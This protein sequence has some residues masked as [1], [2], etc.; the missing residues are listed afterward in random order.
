MDTKFWICEQKKAP[1]TKHRESDM[2]MD[3]VIHYYND[4]NPEL[5]Y[6]PGSLFL[7]N[8]GFTASRKGVL[9][10]R[11]RVIQIQETLNPEQ[12][13]P[14][15]YPFGRH[16]AS[17]SKMRNSWA[18]T[19]ENIIYWQSST[20][21]QGR[22]VPTLHAWDRD[23][24]LT[25]I[26]WLQ[27]NGDAEYVALGSLVNVNANGVA[28]FFGD[29]QP[30]RESIRMILTAIKILQELTDFKVHLMGFGSSPLTLFLAYYLGASST[31]SAGPRRKA[32]YG[33]IV[34]PRAGERY[35]GNRQASFGM[36]TEL[37]ARKGDFEKLDK[38]TC[39]ICI[40]NRDQLWIDWRARALHNEHVMKAEALFAHRLRESG[41]EAYE[42]FMTSLFAKSGLKH[43]WDE[44]RVMNNYHPISTFLE[45]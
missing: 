40:V 11:D 38:C 45:K 23:S 15:D 7:D 34:L 14:L 1:V 4:L 8:G 19:R 31:D 24:L 32:A 6:E 10:N 27:K 44:A 2:V 22:L 28:G 18:K 9:L 26:K 3:S 42:T 35:V 30:R 36:G 39:Q 25:N 16:N 43:L 21:L 13:I 12:T 20:S 17:Q 5:P 37:M 41:P 33:K 29:R